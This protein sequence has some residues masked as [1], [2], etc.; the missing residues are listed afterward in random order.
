MS[1]SRT[2][3][4]YRRIF[5]G[6]PMPFAFVDLDLL[7]NNAEAI[8]ARARGK[9]V[10]LGTKGIRCAALLRKILDHR[11]QFAGLMC[12]SAA[13][14]VFL[15]RKGFDDLLIAYPVWQ[16][17]QLEALCDEVRS[18]RQLAVMFDSPDHLQRY[19]AVAAAK[20]V[21]LNVCLD[22]DVASRFPFLHFGV[23]WSEVSGERKIQAVCDQLS[24]LKN[25]R[26]VGMMGYEA[27]IAGLPDDV[28]GDLKSPVVRLLKRLSAAA[29]R[30]K[31]AEA[32]AVLTKAGHELRFVN[33]GGTGSLDSTSLDEVVTEVTAGSGFYSPAS[34]DH[35]R[36]FRHRPAAAYAV[37][38]TRKGTRGAMVCHGGGY[39]AS[40]VATRLKEPVPYLPRGVRLSRHEGAGEVQTPVVYRGREELRLGDPLFFRHA[41]AGELCERVNS[42]HLV[43]QGRIVGQVPTYRGEGMCFL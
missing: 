21:V 29:V 33:G 20:G 6:V 22:L 2:Y 10:R 18:A 19:D 43:T 23:K 37:E 35:Y 38:I 11:A 9:K 5:R 13:E 31:R 28:K 4:D 24:S 32:A 7:W 8:A 40:G 41:K 16:Q 12:F 27:Q 25:V 17:D 39:T 15:S 14:A 42:L 30:K 3:D 1:D 36:D 26:L 34:F